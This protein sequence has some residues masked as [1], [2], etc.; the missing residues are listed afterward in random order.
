VLGLAR[1]AAAE[2]A[3]HGVRVNC[4]IP[5]FIETPLLHGIGGDDVPGAMAAMGSKVPQGRIGQPEECAAL[6]CFL[7]SD[8]AS[9]ITAQSIAVDGGL[10]GTLIP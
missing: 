3:A 7:L 9:H 6:V 4:L 1:A 8:A 5:G 10:L 2:G